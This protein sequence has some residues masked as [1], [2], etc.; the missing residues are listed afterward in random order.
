MIKEN[1]P[2]FLFKIARIFSKVILKI[3]GWKT[4]GKVP[5]EKKYVLVGYPHTSNWDTVI[6]L[7]SYASMGVRLNWL[8]KQS[9]FKW[10][11]GGILKLTGAIPVNRQ[12]SQNFI[13]Y[14]KDLFDRYER[15]VLTL[16]PE[17]TRKKTEYWRTGFYYMAL[18]AGVPIALGILDYS[19]KIG[20]FGP[21]IWPSG[22]IEKDIAKIREFYKDF[23]GKYPEKMGEI[24]IN[25]E[26]IK[27]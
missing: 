25:P 22:D 12:Q 8:A 3:T 2:S 24:R 26:K 7:M 5:E 16:S 15:L 14:S 21:L 17:G 10:P 13:Q 1:R 18:N 4:V 27:K 23:K 11:L 6:G 9:L 19:K 20:G